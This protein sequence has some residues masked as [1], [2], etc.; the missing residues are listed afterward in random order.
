M[1]VM[2]IHELFTSKIRLLLQNHFSQ[3]RKQFP[4]RLLCIIIIY[5]SYKYLLIVTKK[6]SNRSDMSDS[7]ECKRGDS[8]VLRFFMWIINISIDSFQN[9]FV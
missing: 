9:A 5:S 3:T 8:S 2:G 1:D 6:I 4:Q 7:M